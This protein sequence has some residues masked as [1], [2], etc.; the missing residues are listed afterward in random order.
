[1]S[2]D[3]KIPEDR[4]MLYYLGN[5]LIVVGFL[6]FVSVIIQ[7]ISLVNSGP[8]FPPSA[9]SPFD[10]MNRSHRSNEPNFM[11]ALAGMGLVLVGGI[12]RS[13]GA[14][15]L[16]GSGILIDPERQREELKPWSKMA[17]GMLSDALEEVET[18][19]EDAV[20]VEVVKV[21]C[22]SCR[23]LNDENAKFCD[24]CGEPL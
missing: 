11:V 24:Q 7:G 15:G 9:G 6:L 8:G 16:A 1:M 23:A 19:P 21:R 20:P 22:R 13:V 10:P 14:A 12:C 5:I 18:S 17:G 3:H 4:A 2:N